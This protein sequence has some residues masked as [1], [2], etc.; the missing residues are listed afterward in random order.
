MNTSVPVVNND[1]VQGALLR[2]RTCF[3]AALAGNCVLGLIAS[4]VDPSVYDLAKTFGGFAGFYI[5]TFININ[6]L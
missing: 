1:P 2:L 6:H 5:G 4:V 3:S